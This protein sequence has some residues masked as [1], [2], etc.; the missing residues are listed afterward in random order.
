MNFQVG[1]INEGQILNSIEYFDPDC[2]AWN[3][4]PDMKTRRAEVGVGVVDG[5]LYAIGGWNGF[6][7]YSSVEVFDPAINAW[8]DVSSMNR[9]RRS[10]G[11]SF[12]HV[13]VTCC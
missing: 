4:G 1:G 12:K 3:M 11:I 9:P 8:T 10:S 7:T 2:P 13:Q 6:T 5:R